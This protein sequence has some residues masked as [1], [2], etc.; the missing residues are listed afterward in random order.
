MLETSPLTVTLAVL[1]IFLGGW[2]LGAWM[3]YR[4]IK[5]AHR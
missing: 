3:T 1:S 2:I 5:W 4:V